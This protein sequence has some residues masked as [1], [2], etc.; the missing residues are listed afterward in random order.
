MHKLNKAGEVAFDLAKAISSAA[1]QIALQVCPASADLMG[2]TRFFGPL[3]DGCQAFIDNSGAGTSFS[4]VYQMASSNLAISTAATM[5]GG[6]IQAPLATRVR[7]ALAVLGHALGPKAPL[8]E[9]GLRATH[10]VLVTLS[11][12]A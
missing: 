1:Q 9:S 10:L 8:C 4:D 11:R 5:N 2:A 7:C 12:E 6:M 3:A